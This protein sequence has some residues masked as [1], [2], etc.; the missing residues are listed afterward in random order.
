MRVTGGSH[1]FVHPKILYHKFSSIIDRGRVAAQGSYPRKE[2]ELYTVTFQNKRAPGAFDK[3]ISPFTARVHPD[4]DATTLVD[5][6]CKEKKLK[7][8]KI[9]LEEAD[10]IGGTLRCLGIGP[11]SAIPWDL[12]FRGGGG[13]DWQGGG[14]KGKM[15]VGAGGRI[16]Q[17]I[18]HDENPADYWCDSRA[19]L[20]NVTF[21]TPTLFEW[22]TGMACPPSPITMETYQEMGYPMFE[23]TDEVPSDISSDFEKVKSVSAFKDLSGAEKKYKSEIEDPS[24][25]PNCLH[26]KIREQK[27]M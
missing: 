17:S 22:F 24:I 3:L 12:A 9:F 26:C 16:K 11:G 23:I 4:D 2:N 20:L 8:A 27:C 14:S 15:S 5:I 25:R 1:G 19:V 18:I 6:L 21:L 10:G 13:N 7:E